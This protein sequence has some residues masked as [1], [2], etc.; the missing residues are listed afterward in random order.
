MG[1]PERPLDPEGGPVERFA[2]AL[3]ELRR[4]AGGI[5]YR[6]MAA[7]AG[8][9]A[10][11]LSEAAAGER[12]PSLAVALAYVSACGGD[13]EEWERRWQRAAEDAA[14]QVPEGDGSAAPYRGLARFE[15]GDS[16]CF[17]GRD[18]LVADL[19][20][21]VLGS[22]FVAVVGTSGSGKSSLLRAG[23]IP[24][25]RGGDW[26]GERPA[27]IRILTP[28]A[29]P[30]HTHAR[31][32]VPVDG[33][34]DTWVVVDQFEE[35]FTL[36]R[37]PAERARFIDMLL[38]AVRPG[39]RLRVVIAV[40]ADFYGRC[41]EHRELA[42][43]LR[44]AG[45]LV[46][47]MSVEELREAIVKP[48][49][50]EGLVVERALTARIIADVA[51]QPGG[52]PLMSHA[53]METWRRRRGGALTVKGYEAVGGVHGAIARTAEECYSGLSAHEAALARQVMLRL[54][55]PGE[56]TDDTSRPARR[57]E[58]AADAATVLDR[59][60]GARLVTLDD[61]TVDL[62]HEALITAWPRLNGWIESDRELLRR[63]RLLTEAATA[64]E[65]LD[66][67]AGVLYRGARLTVATEAF[68]PVAEPDPLTPLERAFLT[69]SLD[70]RRHEQRQATRTSRR[71]R[72][73]TTAL[74]ILVAL[75]VVAGLTA[76]NQSTASTRQ[77]LQAEARRIAAMA[78]SLRSS[79][80]RTA[81]RLSAAAY[82]LA[83][84]PDSRSALL[85]SY[86]QTELDR[87]DP[88]QGSAAA[89]GDDDPVQRFL[90]RD[91]RVLTT[92]TDDRVERWDTSTRRRTGSFPGTGDLEFPGVQ[93]ISPDGGTL[94]IWTK[95]G[96]RL[97][98][99]DAGRRVGARIGSAGDSSAGTTGSFVTDTRILLSSRYAGRSGIRFRLWD[100]A[101]GRAVFEQNLRDESS[102][103]AVAS[104]DGRLLAICRRLG[105]VQVWDT[106]VRR[107]LPIPWATANRDLCP[108]R[109]Q[110]FVSA[111]GDSR[112]G[113]LLFTPDSRAL[114]VVG[115][116]PDGSGV[117]AWDLASGKQ[118]LRI[119]YSW[120]KDARTRMTFGADGA[121]VAAA[122]G[123]EI[124]LW[125]TADPAVPVLRHP[126]SSTGSYDLDGTSALRLDLDRR[127]IRYL[128]VRGWE[129]RISVA[130]LALDEAL[131]SVYPVGPVR[132][133]TYSPDG[134]TLAAVRRLDGATRFQLLD[135]ATAEVLA[136]LPNPQM[137]CLPDPNCENHTA[138]SADG[139]TFA[140]GA[141]PPAGR[142][143]K[144]TFYVWD[145]RT[146]R[147]IA[148][149][150]LP[151]GVE[152]IG[153]SP[154]GKT[155]LASR[156][157]GSG[158]I[159]LW[160]VRSRT[161]T[162][163]L[164][165]VRDV[166]AVRP[167][168]RLLAT[169]GG[170]YVDLPSGKVTHRNA[171]DPLSAVVFSSDGRYL[172]V[173]GRGG[174][175][176]WDGDARRR[177]ANLPAVPDGDTAGATDDDAQFV[178]AVAFSPDARYL[179]VGTA[180]GTLQ[181]WQTEAPH[182]QPTV[183]PALGGR[184]QSV[185]FGPDGDTLYAA[186]TH[187]RSRSYDL[188]PEH[189]VTTVCERAGGGLSRADWQSYLPDVP[190]RD[191]C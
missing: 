49:A 140:Y 126:L 2:F 129:R 137:F 148:S 22:R 105:P 76:W 155:F 44:G 115:D 156:F 187:R 104:P 189:V 39:S 124:L 150:S 17:F 46:G 106:V 149:L 85:D 88:G 100:T 37:E 162:R 146:H 12:L 52:L 33:G 86:A 99:V 168:G 151:A 171:S 70:A 89:G 190:Y 178:T 174:V 108:S 165:G 77:Q 131:D 42:A 63:H 75:A 48:A 82:G 59:L 185:A 128:E 90:S 32:L 109:S 73:L 157:K 103:D 117:R 158:T 164:S 191:V 110:G 10:A 60:V 186:S 21:L 14:G 133:A 94:M 16:G 54:V 25:L 98:D 172:A 8:Y 24:V 40:R 84:L 67:D 62:A 93:G 31:A 20:E 179:A 118:R 173:G 18:Q 83:D 182:L 65:Q 68:T 166:P 27:A 43:A 64:W 184:V 123:D 176:I 51:D 47:P 127:R 3:R 56:G 78:A 15:P 19:A 79:D 119:E 58:L 23:L 45:L 102:A 81:M 71:L 163:V 114:A 72:G 26:A 11:T 95:D 188:D 96:L 167:D 35:V 50:A 139:G 159:E 92:V 125:R 154:D 135:A 169:S 161:R 61:D 7:E 53:L 9:T 30:A 134:R 74:T 138:F 144:V 122:N 80:P 55:A 120:P 152:G 13:A 29:R 107:R 66:R 101:L 97:W 38:T 112:E 132:A 121:F 91:G 141:K 41:G 170:D 113:R 142:Y 28:G 177:L 4:E 143:S 69:A 180:G 6:A 1:R 34:G 145:T 111:A 136:D 153:L 147:Q 5:T 36:C 57:A 87:F 116:F 175:T 160:D 181:I 130:S 183:F